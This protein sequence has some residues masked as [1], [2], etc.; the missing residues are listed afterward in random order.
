MGVPSEE[1]ASRA[2]EVEALGVDYI[3]IHRGLGVKD[4]PLENLKILKETVT[5]SQIAIAGGI[6]LDTLREIVPLK[7]DLV[8]V[9]SAIIRAEN[10]LLMAR[11][12]R[13]IMK[14]AE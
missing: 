12:M 7:P 3:C 14:E 13:N 1:M 11:T 5:Q 8:I 2:R 4:S 6:D 9:G 10:P